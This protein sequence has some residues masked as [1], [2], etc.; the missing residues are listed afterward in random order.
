VEI[1]TVWQ[2][3][4]YIFN[5]IYILFTSQETYISPANTSAKSLICG[6]S[7]MYW[8]LILQPYTDC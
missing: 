5:K 8:Y 2:V 3:A 6:L 1:R 7:Y 4:D